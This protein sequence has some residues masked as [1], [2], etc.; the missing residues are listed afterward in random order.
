MLSYVELGPID[1]GAFE[2]PGDSDGD[3]LL[4]SFEAAQGL[5]PAN[6]FTKASGVPDEVALHPGGATCFEVQL[7]GSAPESGGGG[8]GGA[9][10]LTG[11][12][13][14]LLLALRAA[15]R[16]AGGGG[17]CA[18]RGAASTRPS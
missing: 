12:E 7:S 10:G 11:L 2:S 1:P 14:L 3:G 4:D 18:S 9:R 8:G 15:R 17:R 13:A 16:T 6:A 5:D